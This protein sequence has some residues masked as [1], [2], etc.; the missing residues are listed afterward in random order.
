[1][2]EEYPSDLPF[3]DK[4]EH[5]ADADFEADLMFGPASPAHTKK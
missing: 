2:Y 1:M 5:K 4:V 3:R